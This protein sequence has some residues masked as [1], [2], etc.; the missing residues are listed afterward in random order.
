MVTTVLRLAP[1]SVAT[2]LRLAVHG[3]EQIAAGANYKVVATQPKFKAATA[4][5]DGYLQQHCGS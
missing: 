4:K 3:E 2:S 5:L 1:P